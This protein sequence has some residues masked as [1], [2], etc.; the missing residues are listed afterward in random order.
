MLEEGYP[1]TLHVPGGYANGIKSIEPNSKLMVFSEFSIED[2]K[3]DDYRFD[4]DLWYD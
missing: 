3:R 2:G 4:K 1:G